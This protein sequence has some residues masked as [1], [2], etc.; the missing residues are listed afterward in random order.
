MAEYRKI[1]KLVEYILSLLLP[2]EDSL[3][4]RGDYEEIYN[5][6]YSEK[7]KWH[8]NFWLARQVFNAFPLYIYDS[9][10]WRF[11]ML[12]H[13]I[14]I[15]FRNI[16]RHKGYSFLNITGLAV[17][18]TLFILIMI[19]VQHEFSYDKFNHNLDRIYRLETGGGGFKFEAVNGKELKE[20]FP[21]DFSVVRF[22]HSHIN[23]LLKYEDTS[24][25][26]PDH[27]FADPEVFDVFTFRFVAGDPATALNEPFTL[28]LTEGVA[29]KIF[30]ELNPVGKTLNFNNRQD[31]KITGVIKDLKTSHMRIDSI[32]SFSSLPKMYGGG[33]VDHGNW[34][35]PTY[36]LLSKNQ[37]KKVIE[38]KITDHF[39]RIPYYKEKDI[40]F[41]LR[42]LEKIYFFGQARGGFNT[43][44]VR[45]V[46]LLIL[47]AVFIILIAC[48]N[49]INL[50]TADASIRAKEIGIKKVLGSKRSNIIL[51]F[52]SESVLISLFA[53]GLAILLVN[54]FLP[55]FNSL[56]SA[57]LSFEIFHQPAALL[58]I[59]IG[60]IGVGIFSGLYPAFFLTSR[61]PAAMLR[62]E[63]TKGKGGANFRRILIVFQFSISVVLIIGTMTVYKQFKYMKNRDL[64]F[65]KDHIINVKLNDEIIW[66]KGNIELFK[67]KLLQYPDVLRV[68][69]S[70]TI[71]GENPW[72][73]WDY[74]INGEVRQLEI[75]SIDPDYF[76]TLDIKIAQ[77]RNFSWHRESD[78]QSFILNEAAVKYLGLTSPVGQV[79]KRKAKKW[80][81]IGVVKDFHFSSLH[82]ELEPL[83]FHFKK[84]H[85]R[86][87]SIKISANNISRTIAHIKKCWK[88]VTPAFPFYYSFLDESFDL[89]YKTEEKLTGIF[90][91]FA[92]LA[93]FIASLGLIGLAYFIT[94]KRSKEIG[95]R[96][97]YGASVTGILLL[98]SKEFTKWVLI[99]NIFAWP[100]AYIAMNKWLSGFAYRTGIGIEIFLLSGF[101]A[102]F[103]AL[104]TVSLQTVKAAVSNPV[105]ILRYE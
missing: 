65:N 88:A 59:I 3:N 31:F 29:K 13:H 27:V 24:I 5:I 71:P 55:L 98:L 67:E 104:L 62:G 28:V 51:Q 1:P 73:P 103:T 102:L 32:A 23:T 7:G 2:E 25:T 86:T 74:D 42:P 79:I 17:G 53:S 58:L 57:N 39:N 93:I 4:L 11:I 36:L 49:F 37:D 6:L 85:F 40:D 35:F 10:Y 30:G 22:E 95:I 64:G 77:G 60:A 76:A 46:Y 20:H 105:E 63:K 96:K 41:C 33:F 56:I 90:G 44:N 14:K 78:K 81:V 50:S 99:A 34:S 9:I 19:F 12:K 101:L 52:L 87:V 38:G 100:T 94:Q 70:C 61:R 68:S 92:L 97:V 66:R 91:Y 54:L 15:A 21:G 18:M 26:I 80:Q 84:S 69:Y 43:G 75:N 45:I 72:G 47:I 16:L 82:N 83:I 48:T 89:Q 8:V